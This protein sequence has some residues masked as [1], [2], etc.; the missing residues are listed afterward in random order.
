MP[1]T[2]LVWTNAYGIHSHTTR[3]GDSNPIRGQYTDIGRT[4]GVE[5]STKPHRDSRWWSGYCDIPSLFLVP[6]CQ[7]FRYPSFALFF[8]GILETF[9]PIA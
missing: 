3:L 5:Y 7:G 4:I 9:L 6:H 1:K 8:M 2:N